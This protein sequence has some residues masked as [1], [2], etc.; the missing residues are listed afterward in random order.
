MKNEYGLEVVNVR[1]VKEQTL[2]S[3]KPAGSPNQAVEIVADELASMDREVFCVMNLNTKGKVVNL[4]VVSVGVLDS[5]LVHPREVF[6]SVILSNAAAVILLHNHPSGVVEPSPDD[7]EATARLI[8][9]GE[10]LGIKVVD[11]IIVGSGT[12]EYYS[13]ANE[14]DLDR[15]RE[16]LYR[17]R[18][19]EA[20]PER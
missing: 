14:G 8:E 18:F 6:K 15:I 2:Y 5:S 20:D 3:D 4:N 13:F 10:I 12:G 19:R 17:E 7:Y 9:A 1:L 11:H 16:E